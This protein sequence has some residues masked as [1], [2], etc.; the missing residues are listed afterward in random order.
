MVQDSLKMNAENYTQFLDDHFFKW[1]KAQSRSFKITS[2]FMHGN[3]P[4]HAAR[5]TTEYLLKKGIKNEWIM[6]WP[7]QSP[8][9]NPIENLWSKAKR[10][11]YPG[12]QQYKS[13]AEVWDAIQRICAAL[14][15][16]D[17]LNLTQSMDDRLCKVVQNNGGYIKMYWCL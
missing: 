4:S 10:E 14:R 16:H 17:I 6:T 11:R 5:Y 2:I 1:Y 13:K 7:S 8:Y 15:P 9:I 3:C 12:D